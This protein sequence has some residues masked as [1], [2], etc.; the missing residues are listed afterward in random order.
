MTLQ[1]ILEATA[2]AA[3]ITV[4]QLKSK[5]RL[6]EIVNARIVFGQLCYELMPELCDT[7]VSNAINK[8]RTAVIYYR[9]TYLNLADN[10]DIKY[11]YNAVMSK[12]GVKGKSDF[13]KMSHSELVK[14]VIKLRVL[15]MQAKM[16]R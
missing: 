15:L 1:S 6:Q 9:R 7:T 11:I 10:Y 12:L 16:K 3:G 13:E 2:E 8:H 5:S 14:E 4:E